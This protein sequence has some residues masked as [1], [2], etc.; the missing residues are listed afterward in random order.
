MNRL[1]ESESY[2]PM[3]SWGIRMTFA[4]VV[5]LFFGI[6]THHAA[7]MMWVII[8][9]ESIGWVELKGSF[10]QRVRVLLGGAFL[11]MIFGFAGAIS[12]GSLLLSI[13]MMLLVVFIATLFKNLGERGSG[14]SL[15]VY[16]MFITANAFPVADF[17][18][19]LERCS[20]IAIGGAWTFLVGTLAS[21]FMTEQMPYKRSV[22]LIW[23][24]TAALA[25]AIDK[26]WDGNAQKASIREIY[27]KEKEVNDAIDS[28]LQLYDKRVYQ[29][30]ENENAQQMAHF[31]KSTCLAS[32]TLLVISEELNYVQMTALT[33]AQRQSIHAILK[34]CA[35]VCERMT[36]YTVSAKLEEEMLLRSRLLRLQNMCAVLRDSEIAITERDAIYK[37]L[38]YTE[39]LVKLVENSMSTISAVAEDRKVYRSYSLMKTLLI[40]HHKHWVD[41]VRR[42]AN[43]NTHSFRYALRTAIVATLALFLYKWFNIQ[44]GYWLPFTVMIVVQPYFGATLKKAL[45]R[46]L[47]TVLGVV[48]GGLLLMLPIELHIKTL[49][50]VISPVLMVYFLRKQYSVA[51][52]FISIFLVTLFA[53]ENSYDTNVIIIRSL[54]T[55]GGAALAVVGEFA[56]LPTWDK[57]F[58]P[59]HIA[60]AI[61]DNY[62]YFLFTFYPNQYSSIHQWTHYRRLAESS[63]S[64]AF[65]SFNRYLQEP[66]SKGKDYTLLYQMVAHCIRVTR[67]LNNYHLEAEADKR[68]VIHKEFAE[69]KLIIEACLNQ[70]VSIQTAL[71]GNSL[72]CNT[73]GLLVPIS[74]LEVGLLPL[75]ETQAVYLD[76]LHIELKTFARDAQKWLLKTNGA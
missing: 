46:V 50:L 35:I 37:M 24:S 6:L 69:K 66:T 70:F 13:L 2:E 25:Y 51:T 53:A 59:K 8:A 9:S 26:G 38:I 33:G 41:S 47:G 61:Q 27:L 54:C 34:S 15:T 63:N 3:L 75:N 4:V 29:P 49:L 45:D 44:H 74:E 23:K 16:V 30:H 57:Q 73:E 76:R 36:I 11:A 14:L 43:I 22:A 39:R 56:L 5:P 32:A 7:E 28:S 71:Q 60:K 64:N 65:D 42:L 55:I 67:E 21:L 62:N 12:N 20:Y 19:V 48:V 68:F 17:A 40:L 1:I 58:L 10:A 72:D 31:R 18:A 52:F